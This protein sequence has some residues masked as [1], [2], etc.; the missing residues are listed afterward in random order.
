LLEGVDLR[1][2]SF[3]EGRLYEVD[4]PVA[5]VLLSWGYAERH[6]RAQAAQPTI[7]PRTCSKCGSARTT[8]M[9][10][11]EIP[12]LAHVHCA[13]CGYLSVHPLV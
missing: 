5:K 7:Q 3:R 10:Q 2:Y 8:V 13:S 1:P 4:P 9:G 11:S 12:P 6:P